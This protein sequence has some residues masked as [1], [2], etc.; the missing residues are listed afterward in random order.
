VEDRL[1]ALPAYSEAAS[2][3]SADFALNYASHNSNT[4]G[5]ELGVRNN[6]SGAFGRNWTLR[7]SDRLAWMHDFDSAY[8][9]L[10]SYA[11]LPGSQFTTFGAQPGRDFALLSLDAEARNRSGMMLG[12]G[13]ETSVSHQSQSYYGMGRFGFTW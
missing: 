6:F 5:T 13:L 10:A 12:L 9:A 4:A 7:F 3:G 1:V 11:A 8:T 2:S